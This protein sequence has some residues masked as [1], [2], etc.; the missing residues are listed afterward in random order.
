MASKI[1]TSAEAVERL[2]AHI[3]GGPHEAWEIVCTSTLRALAAERD[4]AQSALRAREAEVG[5]LR[6]AVDKTREAFDEVW[7]FYEGEHYYDHP[8][9]VRVRALIE[10]ADAL[11]SPIPQPAAQED[12]L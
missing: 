9:S 1:D 6:E 5:R 7:P 10:A 11:A 12:T 4:A 3:T 8:C 2:A